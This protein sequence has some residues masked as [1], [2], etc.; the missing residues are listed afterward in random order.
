[1]TKSHTHADAHA[2]IYLPTKVPYPH[3][4]VELEVPRTPNSLNLQTSQ[5]SNLDPDAG[6]YISTSTLITDSAFELGP[7]PTDA[8]STEVKTISFLTGV[9]MT[10]RIS[11]SISPSSHS[12]S[13]HYTTHYHSES[14]PQ[15]TFIPTLTHSRPPTVILCIGF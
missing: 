5:A 3:I 6:L 15:H 7:S 13:P 12:I 2:R 14:V 10:T 8:G 4:D 9:T 11:R 1:M